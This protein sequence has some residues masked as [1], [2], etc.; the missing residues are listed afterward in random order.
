MLFAAGSLMAAD[1]KDDVISAAK[2]LADGGNYSWTQTTAN[3][4]GSTGF[5]TG[6]TEGKTQ[7]NGLIY[8]SREGNNGTVETVLMGTNYAMNNGQDGWQ[9][10]EDLANNGGG[11]GGGGGGG[12]RGGFGRNLVAPAMQIQNLLTNVGDLKESGGA[13]VA[14]F[15]DAGAK[16]VLLPPNFGRG[17]RNGGG[18]GGGGG[19]GAGG[20]NGFTPPEVSDAK[21]S[22]RIWV[23][24][25]V[26]SRYEIKISGTV[27]FNGNDRDIDR[28]T[29]VE[30][31]DVGNTKI[32]VPDD[33]L[34][35]IG[36]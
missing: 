12:R 4:D 29:T 21:G 32:N 27:S 19:G 14:D 13:Y 23:K 24:D 6:A 5:G 7:K 26:L 16:V 30:I 15:T 33:I 35:K 22:L 28:T 20:D 17:R 3:A 34:K 31:K 11:G 25:G 9:T 1:P 2:S 10:A 8:T 18:G 36:G